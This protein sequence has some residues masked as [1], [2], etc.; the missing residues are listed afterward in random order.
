MS[1][2]KKSRKTKTKLSG[3]MLWGLLTKK[4]K[5]QNRNFYFIS[6]FDK[7][8]TNLKPLQYPK[9]GNKKNPQLLLINS[10][11]KKKKNIIDDRKRS[12]IHEM[13][14]EVWNWWRPRRTIDGETANP[15]VVSVA[16]PP[17]K[18]PDGEFSES[19][20]VLHQ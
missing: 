2:I 4:K 10:E 1:E 6:F 18:N 8:F 20:R 3:A 5:S 9:G 12:K 19:R 15:Y 7:G 16:L 14:R 11:R 17:R 13:R